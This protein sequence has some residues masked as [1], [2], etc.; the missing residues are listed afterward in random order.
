LKDSHRIE[1]VQAVIHTADGGGRAV[2]MV[3][4]HPNCTELSSDLS[5][6]KPNFT[7]LANVDIDPNDGSVV[8]RVNAALPRRE[9]VSPAL[10]G[11]DLHNCLSMFEDRRADYI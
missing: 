5:D 11:W 1:A 2:E 7:V 8:D 4:H 6:G 9:E 3:L 10:C